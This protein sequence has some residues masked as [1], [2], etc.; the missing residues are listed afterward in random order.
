MPGRS[1]AGMVRH[2]LV[3]A[4]SFDT[5]IHDTVQLSRFSQHRVNAG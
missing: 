1:G 4:R 2:S 3:L 5:R